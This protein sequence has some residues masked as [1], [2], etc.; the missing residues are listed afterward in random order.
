MLRPW[1]LHCRARVPPSVGG[2]RFL[3]PCDAVENT[4][5]FL[6]LGLDPVATP[7]AFTVIP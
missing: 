5:S 3:K 6:M 4:H 1:H 7:E 2:L